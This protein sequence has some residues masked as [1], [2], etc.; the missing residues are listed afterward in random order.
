[1][2]MDEA[3]ELLAH[4]IGDDVLNVLLRLWSESAPRNAM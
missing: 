4:A 1:M 2:P 3:L